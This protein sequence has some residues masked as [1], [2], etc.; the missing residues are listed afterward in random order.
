MRSFWIIRCLAVVLALTLVSGQTMAAAHMAGEL[1]GRPCPAEHGDH[2]H[3][4]GAPHQHPASKHL[5]CCCDCL[6]C[7]GAA[8]LAPAMPAIPALQ[9]ASIRFWRDAP[10]L[11]GVLRRPETGPPR[12]GAL[13]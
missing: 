2:H 9:L 4:G 13:T 8:V 6:F 11:A 5:A 3:S 10:E 1:P 7:A 12:P